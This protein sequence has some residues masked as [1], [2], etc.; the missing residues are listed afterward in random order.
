[1]SDCT[2]CSRAAIIRRSISSEI[3]SASVKAWYRTSLLFGDVLDVAY[4]CEPGLD[5][6]LVVGFPFDIC[7]KLNK[8]DELAFNDALFIAPILVL[9]APNRQQIHI[10]C[11]M[12]D[13]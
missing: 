3:A 1:M 6:A 2:S 5:L 11:E 8:L 13:S 9:D 4:P 12:Y 10:L 7:N